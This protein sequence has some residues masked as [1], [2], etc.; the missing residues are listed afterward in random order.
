MARHCVA[1]E[2]SAEAVHLAVAETSR[3]SPRLVH[4][5]QQPRSE[6]T[7]LVDQLHTL[8]KPYLGGQTEVILAVPGH[9]AFL[10][11][12]SFPFGNRTKI[13]AAIELEMAAQLPVHQEECIVA[14]LPPLREK[15]GF[16]VLAVALPKETLAELVGQ[17]HAWGL[18]VHIVEWLP[19][20]LAIGL[21][22]PLG[23][24]ILL[25]S[26][27]VTTSMILLENGQAA[28]F[29]ILGPLDELSLKEAATTLTR[30]KVML[31]REHGTPSLPI[32]LVGPGAE[33]NLLDHLRQQDLQVDIPLVTTG[34]VPVAPELLPVAAL[35]LRGARGNAAGFNFYR[36]QF[37][38]RKMLSPFH[39]SLMPQVG[40]A[41]VTLLLLLAT[42]VIG[43]LRKVN[44]AAALKNEM[45]QIYRS[46]FPGK[47]PIVDAKAQM[48]GWLQQARGRS[49]LL[50]ADGQGS[51]QSVLTELSRRIPRDLSLTIDNFQYEPDSVRMSGFTTSLE[52]VDRIKSL[53]ADA[54]VFTAVQ[55][56]TVKMSAD[57]KR[58]EFTLTFKPRPE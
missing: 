8:A 5:E 31:E 29:R 3:K 42:L 14:S 55:V 12:L 24:A 25:H 52:A 35:A 41:I 11:R 47:A 44:Q 21:G 32:Y 10:R 51:A 15:N 20:A 16:D 27:P 2:I 46:T 18:P 7:P 17:F 49:R 37:D 38:L 53:V 13:Q 28:R 57:G 36:P 39:R 48:E 33:R 54:P 34:K 56:A 9:K 6:D 4:V 43:D 22:A 45:E 26:D 1:L 58:A 23:N 40:L 50:Q 19:S 30:A